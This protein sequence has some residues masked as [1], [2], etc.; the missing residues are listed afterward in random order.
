[1]TREA[2]GGLQAGLGPARSLLEMRW[3][4]V[5]FEA[6]SFSVLYTCNYIIR[7]STNRAL[8][9]PPGLFIIPREERGLLERTFR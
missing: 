7:L 3:I 8:I 5:S 2:E 9:N 4:I 1:M 6:V